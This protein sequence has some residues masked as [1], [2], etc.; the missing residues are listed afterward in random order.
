VAVTLAF[1]AQGALDAMLSLRP[2]RSVDAAAGALIVREAGGQV[3]FP[4]A[5]E[6]GSLGLEMRS[7]VLAARDPELLERLLVD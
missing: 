3:A 2:I 5:G 1:V 6:R 7:R 4:E